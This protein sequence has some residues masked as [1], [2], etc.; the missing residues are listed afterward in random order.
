MSHSCAPQVDK[1]EFYFLVEFIV[2]TN[3]LQ[4]EGKGAGTAAAVVETA[5]DAK[6]A[7]AEGLDIGDNKFLEAE[8]KITDEMRAELPAPLVE[9]L[10]SEAFKGMCAE[11]FTALDKDQNGKPFW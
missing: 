4:A 3:C 11:N 6:E 1:D 5:E 9:Q 2:V 7:A 8:S 10:A